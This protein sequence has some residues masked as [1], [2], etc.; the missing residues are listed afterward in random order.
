MMSGEEGSQGRG[1]DLEE[2][3]ELKAT[4]ASFLQGSPET[5][6]KE[7]EKTP[8]EPDTADFS[9]WVKWKLE[10]QNPRLVGGTVSSTR[11]GRCQ[12]TSQGGKGVLHAS[13][14][15]AGAG[16]KGGHSPSSPCT[17]MSLQKEVYAPSQLHLCMQGHLRDPKGK[18]GGICQGPPVLGR[19]EQPTC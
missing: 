3:L 19:A 6:D 14:V 8:L 15:N 5:L 18:S 10:V 1:S 17:T 7:G 12:K 4:V 9:Q 16:L 2:P 13:T 11:E